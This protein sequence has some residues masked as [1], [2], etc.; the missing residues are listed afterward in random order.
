LSGNAGSA[1]SPAPADPLESAVDCGPAPE[2]ASEA[3]LDSGAATNI[4]C[5]QPLPSGF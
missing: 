3:Q 5:P 2:N 1:P 4:H